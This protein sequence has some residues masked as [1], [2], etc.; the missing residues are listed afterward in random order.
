MVTLSLSTS[1]YYIISIALSSIYFFSKIFTSEI[2][3]FSRIISI[4]FCSFFFFL[5]KSQF[6]AYV[7]YPLKPFSK[8]GLLAKLSILFCFTLCLL[9]GLALINLLFIS[10]WFPCFGCTPLSS[11]VHVFFKGNSDMWVESYC[12]SLFLFHFTYPLT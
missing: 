7:L 6:Y 10:Q 1:L 2:E 3:F 12:P 5:E 11:S 8:L 4:C 9:L